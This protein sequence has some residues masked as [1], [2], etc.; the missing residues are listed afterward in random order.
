M[1]T[2]RLSR[3]RRRHTGFTLI[4]LLVVI[5]II[6]ILAAM[7]L[8]ALGKAK[9]KAKGI[10][11]LSNQRQ[12]G[13]AMIMYTGDNNDRVPLFGDSYPY[14][15]KTL[16]W[17]QYVG[18]YVLK[19]SSGVAGNSAEGRYA[20]ARKCPAG[21]VGP[22]PFSDPSLSAYDDWNCWLGVHFG[23][24]SDPIT[25]PFW[26][27]SPNNMTPLVMTRVKK[28]VDAMLYMDVMQHFVYTPRQAAFVKDV[29]SD[30]MLDSSGAT[31][32][33]FNEGR[34]NIHNGGANVTLMDGHSERVPMK[35][36]WEWRDGKIVHSY[37]YLDD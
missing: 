3:F 25:S 35:R 13:L 7:L 31:P 20:E 18:P 8:P 37:W 33:P 1:S 17:F 11:C 27:G 30:G 5:A 16:F 4:E 15:S 24:S 21:R 9:D 6:A 28:P 32:F 22:P 29:D 34:P 12:W 19:A 14:G 26:Y 36:L 2:E 10:Q 23:G